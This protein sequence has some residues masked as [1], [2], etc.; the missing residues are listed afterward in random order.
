[1][2]LAYYA[3]VVVNLGSTMAFDFGMFNKPCIYLAY[4]PV[5]NPNTSVETIYNFEHFGSMPSKDVVFW[6]NEPSAFD[7]ILDSI[8][9]GKQ[10]SVTTWM[11]I[12]TVDRFKASA[13]IKKQLGV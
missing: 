9:Q 8:E 12:V 3:D 4:N 11:D 13:A 10:T 5:E 7:S 1:M 6:L 2:S